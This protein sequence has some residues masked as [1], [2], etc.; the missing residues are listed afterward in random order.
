MTTLLD[1][2]SE[3]AAKALLDGTVDAVFL[4]GEDA[5]TAIMRKLL[6]AT[7]VHLLNFA[8]AE[9]YTRRF[10]YL[11]VLKLPQGT[12]DLGR[13]IATRMEHG[14]PSLRPY[15]FIRENIFSRIR[16]MDNEFSRLE[17]SVVFLDWTEEKLTEFVE[18]RFVRTFNTKPALGGD[19]WSCFFDDSESFDSR[20]EIFSYDG[21]KCIGC[22][23]SARLG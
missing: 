14:C 2:E 13:N 19:A 9:A 17:T 7:D 11:S 23:T 15:L 18:R 16:A 20:K 8:Q 5:S 21:T 22:E 1:W 4:M 6:V 3:E 12:I 10:S